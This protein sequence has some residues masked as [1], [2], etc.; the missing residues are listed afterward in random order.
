[1]IDNR[2]VWA[3]MPASGIGERMQAEL[4]KQYLRFQGKTILEHTLDRLL[5]FPA[6]D[7]LMLVISEQDQFWQDLDYQSS[8]PLLV[9]HGGKER[10]HSVMNGLAALAETLD[11]DPLVLVHDAVRPLVSHDD[12][13]QVTTAAINDSSG[14]LLAVPVADTLKRA[15]AEGLVDG[16]VSRECLWRAQTPQVFDLSRLQMALH[17]ALL[18]GRLLTDDCAAMEMSGYHPRLVQ[19]SGSN[20]K[21]TMPEDLAMAEQIWL[22][23]RDQH[24]NK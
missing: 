15:N 11:D 3:V 8:K 2:S 1:M 16:T 24:H 10:I 18:S 14:A 17:A 5:S 6:L 4:P 21:I 19:G 12:L 9:T 22:Y 7:G 13:L 23:Q 20:I